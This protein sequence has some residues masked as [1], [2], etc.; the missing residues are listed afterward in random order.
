MSNYN[1]EDYTFEGLCLL[2]P[3]SVDTLAYLVGLVDSAENDAAN[4]KKARH[5]VLY[6]LSEGESVVESPS[7]LIE[8]QSGF[9]PNGYYPQTPVMFV[10]RWSPIIAMLD[11]GFVPITLDRLARGPSAVAS[12]I[13]EPGTVGEVKPF[14]NC[15]TAEDLFWAIMSE[16]FARATERRFLVNLIA[17]P[18]WKY[19]DAIGSLHDWSDEEIAQ[20][21]R[22]L[23]K[24][25][26]EG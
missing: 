1:I 17:E 20:A 12:G 25:T 16:V 2:G 18:G 22:I 19:E 5:K 13:W 15:E 14:F 23:W 9:L 3:S 24:R 8:M 10:R 4:P 21:D 11:K 26:P 7:D 6:P